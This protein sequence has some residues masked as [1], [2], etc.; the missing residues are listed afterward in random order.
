M[1]RLMLVT[2][3]ARGTCHARGV[4]KLLSCNNSA[5]ARPIVLKF[6]V[7][8]GATQPPLLHKSDLGCRRTCARAYPFSKF[9]FLTL[10]GGS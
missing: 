5:M 9:P 2:T 4:G 1:F 6:G 7:W 3:A 8:L 10:F